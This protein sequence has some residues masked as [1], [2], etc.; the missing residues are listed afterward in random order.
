VIVGTISLSVVSGGE[1]GTLVGPHKIV[2]AERSFSQSDNKIL[3]LGR[4]KDIR[5][6]SI[7]VLVTMFLTL[8]MATAAMA[9]DL[10]VGTWKLNLAKSKYNPGS[11]PQSSTVTFTAQDSGLKRV[12][13]GVGAEGKTT[14]GEIVVKYGGKDYTITGNSNIDT[15]PLTRIDANTFELVAKKAGK[16]VGRVWEVISKD[17]KTMTTT[18][19]GKNPQGYF[20][21]TNV[22][23]KQ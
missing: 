11:L 17:G 18:S 12:S 21:N 23:D 14:H 9:A 19:K 13:D 15:I 7:V 10:H 5:K 16:E 6:H 3:K 20:N 4:N 8:A 22:Y 1:T 2:G